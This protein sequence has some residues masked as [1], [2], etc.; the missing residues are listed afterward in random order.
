MNLHPTHR[1]L[2]RTAFGLLSALVLGG[3]AIAQTNQAPSRHEPVRI[4]SG[5]VQNT[6]SEPEV[7]AV[8]NVSEPGAAWMRIRFAETL[9][10]GSVAA[11]TGTMLRITSLHDGYFQHLNAQTLREWQNQSAYFNGDLLQVEVIAQPNTGPNSVTVDRV[12]VGFVPPGEDTI[13]G[14]DDRVLS[15]DPRAARLLPIGCTSFLIDDACGCFGT[16]GHC[17]SGNVVQFNVPLSTSGGGLVNPPPQDQYAVDVESRQSTNGGQGNDWGYF[18]CFP[19]STTGLTPKQAQGQTYQLTT[20][21]NWFEE[22]NVR[23]TG[24]GVDGGNRNQV[25]QT[26]AGPWIRY[27]GGTLLAYQADTQ[28]GNSGSPVIQE[29]SGIV[30]GVHTHGGCTSSSTGS[31][32]G[33]SFSHANWQNALA[34]PRGI[35]KKT[36]PSCST[37]PFTAIRNGTGVNPLCLT[38]ITDPALGTSWDMA[39]DVSQVPGGTGSVIHARKPGAPIPSSIGEHLLEPRSRQIFA[40]V[41]QGTGINLHSVNIP[42]TPELAG[43]VG[44]IQ[45]LVIAQDTPLQLCNAVDFIVG[46][47]Q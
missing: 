36:T 47:V 16:A 8:F 33:T 30:M 24:Y 6:G 17:I 44:S 9:L 27:T 29:E 35:C 10:S 26:H 13:C 34:N 19:N 25:Q 23:I 5:V 18:G 2:S 4:T 31:N 1:G 41:R 15:F 46:C 40:T 38:S 21:P 14:I 45:A 7:V 42:P 20:P 43:W 11:G 12:E 22:S 3:T 39:V 37:V 28:G 32:K